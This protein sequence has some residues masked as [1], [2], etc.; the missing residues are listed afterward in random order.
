LFCRDR[1]DIRHGASGRRLF[2]RFRHFSNIAN[3]T[4]VADAKTTGTEAFIA[5]TTC[6]AESHRASVKP[7]C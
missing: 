3:L 7:R 2:G 4:N 5:G 6:T 1:D